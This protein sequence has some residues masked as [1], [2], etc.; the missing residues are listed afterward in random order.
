[1]K[2]IGGAGFAALWHGCTLHGTQPDQ[3]DKA[4]VSLRYLVTRGEQGTKCGVDEL[5]ADIGWPVRLPSTRVDLDDAGRA[6]MKRN[7]VNEA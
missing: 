3:A 2:L 6:R 5:D 4:R 7:A 1:M